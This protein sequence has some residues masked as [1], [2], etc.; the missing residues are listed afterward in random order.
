MTFLLKGAVPRIDQVGVEARAASFAKRSIKN[1][2]KLKGLRLAISMMDLT[3]LE[4][5]DTKGKV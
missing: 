4:G 3:T 1:D 2:S 5:A